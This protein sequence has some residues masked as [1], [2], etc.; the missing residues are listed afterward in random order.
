MGKRPVVDK[1]RIFPFGRGV[2]KA[3]RFRGKKAYEAYRAE[4]PLRADQW[5][6]ARKQLAPRRRA[7]GLLVGVER[8]VPRKS[9]SLKIIFFGA[10]ANCNV[11]RGKK[12]VT[13]KVAHPRK[14]E[15]F[16]SFTISIEKVRKRGLLSAVE[17]R[18]I[19]SK[20]EETFGN[21]LSVLEHVWKRAA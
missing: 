18:S 2:G 13:V 21:P 10:E 14:I 1:K 4:K 15:A 20:F 9:I 7:A 12:Y 19:G 5:S 16:A 6:E 3:K 8:R 17:K 11:E